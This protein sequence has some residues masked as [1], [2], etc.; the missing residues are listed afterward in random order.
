MPDDPKPPT[1]TFTIK[2][3]GVET[4]VQKWAISAVSLILILGI[5][6]LVYSKVYADPEK[7]ML[8]LRDANKALAAEVE[9]YSIHAMEEPQ[10]HELFEEQDGRLVLRVFKDHCVLIQRQ[11]LV[12]GTRTKLVVDLARTSRAAER[13]TSPPSVGWLQVAHAQRGCGGGCLNPHP[14]AFK[15]W[16][17]ERRQGGW[18]E[19]W[20]QWPEGCTHVQLFHPPSGAWD[21][22]QDGTARVRWT[23]CVH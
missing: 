12:G 11:T 7:V 15:W 6:W 19:V 18:V 3:F 23:C 2:A 1:G 22:N 20:R 14:G 10:K 21:S 8:S 13:Q 9:E 5:G 4:Q 16:Y 17:G